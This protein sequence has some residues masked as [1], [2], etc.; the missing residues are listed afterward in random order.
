[1][2]L[3]QCFPPFFLLIT[4]RKN[5]NQQINE[6][7]FLPWAMQQPLSRLLSP[8]TSA[9]SLPLQAD[10]LWLEVHWSSD[11]EIVPVQVQIN[12]DVRKKSPYGG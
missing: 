3:V 9:A 1:M 10:C 4:I 6:V 7:V 12:L 5:R 2:V 8:R 11:V